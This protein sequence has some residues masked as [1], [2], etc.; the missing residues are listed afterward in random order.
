MMRVFCTSFFIL[1]FISVILILAFSYNL[2]YIEP[3]NF[4]NH[5]V[6]PRSI[7]ELRIDNDAY[8]IGNSNDIS[9]FERDKWQ[10][11]WHDEFEGK[12]LDHSKWL[13]EDWAAEKNNELQYY[14]PE[15]VKVE[16]GFLKLISKKEKFKGRDY[17]S[18][19]VHTKDK[20]DFLYGKVEMRAK[21]PDGQGI[22]PAFWMLTNKE[23][24]W[25]PE[26]DIMEMLGHRP[27]EVWMVLH[28]LEK[29]GTL[30][31]DAG[32]YKGE[33]FSKGFH[34]FSV[35]WTPDSITWFIDDKKRFKTNAYIPSERMYLYLNTAVGG[36]WPGSPDHK[37]VFP[38]NFEIDYVRVF[39]QK[40]N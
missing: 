5:N 10:L 36:N 35:E 29:D 7:S 19:A 40:S 33:D 14:S 31:K 16:N 27:Q 24:I 37:T 34:I 32:S 15:N 8:K 25:L 26:I 30:K 3:L 9:N 39:K 20:F 17:T 1:C 28:W 2:S 13:T 23:N 22:F 38:K 11:I 12:L 21:L 4:P 6:T 18:A